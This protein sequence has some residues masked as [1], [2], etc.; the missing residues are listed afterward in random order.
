MKE[1]TERL[2][3][4]HTKTL[5]TDK[6]A[7]V[8]KIFEHIHPGDR[9]FIG[10]ACGEPQYLIQSLID[11]AKKNPTALYDAELIQIWT[12]GVAP[13]TDKK[14]EE[15]FRLNSFFV[16]ESTRNAVNVGGA[17]YTPVFLSAVP[18]LFYRGIIPLDV[19]LIQ[20]SPPNEDGDMSL[21]VSVD[22]VKAATEMASL[23][24]AQVNSHMPF[25]YGDGLVNLDEVDYILPHDEPLLEYGEQV[26]ENV[27]KQIGRYVAGL[28]EDGCTLQVG[29]G[30]I[31]NALLSS[32]HDKN[33]LGVHS[34]LFS[35]GLAELMKLDVIDNT[36]KR[37][38][39]GKSVA[40]FCM[41]RKD[42]Y[43]YLHKNPSVEFRTID[44]TN[45]VLVI[46]RQRSMT[47][48]NSALEIDLSGQA[49]AE[50]LG[51]AFYSGIGGQADF[52]RGASLSR[53]G[54]AILA[55]PSTAED[56]LV[57]R[58]V[59][60]L[61]EG[62]GVTLNRGDVRY[63]VTEYGIAYLHG[64]NIRERAMDLIAIAHPKFRP[65]LIEMAKKAS[66]IYRDQAFVP[67]IR[68]EYPEGLEIY[69][70]TK[71][72]LRIM[73]RPVKISDEPL[74]K[75]LFYSLSGPSMYTRFASARKD[76][77]HQRLQEYV[78]VD[79]T[80]TMVILALVGMVEK[81]MAIGL[82]QYI[83]DEATH[84]AELALLVRDE[85]Q[86]KGV[87]RELQSY[88]T[89]LA[90]RQ[91]LL[92]FTAEVLADNTPALQ[93][94]KKTGFKLIYDGNDALEFKLSFN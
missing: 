17:D 27:S 90:K 33:H 21:G 62:A 55:L 14:F 23:V 9:I 59:P 3:K 52:M 11:F 85:Y 45:D 93:L 2:D 76:M 30:S 4:D 84:T 42:T 89:Y 35:D 25:V 24:V 58:I 77:H 15:N 1:D 60:F 51:K 47:A 70:T 80:R 5:F 12:M 28:V 10:T 29:Y 82:G 83:V 13:Y 78:A 36:E 81:E 65:W 18:D 86:G 20:T 64:K 94:V 66:M 87:G 53:G 68:G 8:D 7:S 91:G 73:L 67:G 69:R 37:V 54:K 57:S 71:E 49:T 44:Y 34:E 72:G 88:L 61:Q 22:I 50:S 40:A 43:Q 39:Q 46:A 19:A 38:D 63:V 16:G 31:P 26:P 48:I 79:Y 6:L 75:D 74:L 41:G 56:G 92:G 32:L